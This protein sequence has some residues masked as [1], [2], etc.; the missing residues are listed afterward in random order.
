MLEENELPDK[1]KESTATG[2]SN[3]QYEVKGEDV[4]NDGNQCSQLDYQMVIML[5]VLIN[6][7]FNPNKRD[8]L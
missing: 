6:T 3:Q 8:D 4:V 5:I 1:T 2:V 7:G